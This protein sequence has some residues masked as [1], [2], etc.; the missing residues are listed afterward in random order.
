MQAA[1]RGRSTRH[2]MMAKA[3]GGRTSPRGKRV[4]MSDAE[5]DK[6]LTRLYEKCTEDDD[7]VSVLELE[8]FVS[9]DEKLQAQ[10]ED[11]RPGTVPRLMQQFGVLKGEGEDRVTFLRFVQVIAALQLYIVGNEQPEGDEQRENVTLAAA[12]PSAGVTGDPQDI[13]C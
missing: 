7:G 5:I 1:S 2:R 4:S 12:V 9:A 10:L 11:S 6:A 3:T 8:G 13:T